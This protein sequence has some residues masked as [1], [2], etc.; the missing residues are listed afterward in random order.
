ML[1]ATDNGIYLSSNDGANWSLVYSSSSGA[2]SIAA[3]GSYVYAGIGTT[4]IIRSTNSG[5][6]WAGTSINADV[7]RGIAVS[8]SVV[9][10]SGDAGLY[11]STNN[12]ANWTTTEGPVGT[13]AITISGTNIYVGNYLGVYMSSNNGDNWS[14]TSMT[15]N[16]TCLASSGSNVFAGTLGNGIYV[17]KDNGNTWLLKDEG[18]GVQYFNTLMVYNNYLYAGT[19]FSSVWKR[20][21]QEMIGIRQISEVIPRNYLLHQN[22]PNPFNP[23]TKIRYEVPKAGIINLSVYD[24]LGRKIV[25]LVNENQ[26]AG[27]YESDFNASSLAGGIYFYRLTAEGY[28]ETKKMIVIK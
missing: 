18:M 5:A 6:S 9:F 20:S 24:I 16:T 21:I 8:F 7:V 25:T 28:G 3:S 15:T 14:S 26:S 1:A 2:G 22:Y 27:V 23:V 10:V 12:G 19:Q 13:A 11:R 17:T 4:G